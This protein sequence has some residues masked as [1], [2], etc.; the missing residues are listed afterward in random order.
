MRALGMILFFR[1][2]PVW[3]SYFLLPFITFL[4]FPLRLWIKSNKK[5]ILFITFLLFLLFLVALAT[6]L[7]SPHIFS[8]MLPTAFCLLF[9]VSSSFSFLSSS[10]SGEGLRDS[11]RISLAPIAE[12]S[13]LR[14]SSDTL[15]FKFGNRAEINI[16][17]SKLHDKLYNIRYQNI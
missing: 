15:N 17:I 16:I 5:W 4:R 12:R 8:Y 3:I 14:S 13:I 6:V 2:G 11:L 9:L 7:F 1:S 10:S